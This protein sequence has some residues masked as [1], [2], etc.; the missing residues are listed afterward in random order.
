MVGRNMI[1]I[2]TAISSIATQTS[3]SDPPAKLLGRGPQEKVVVAVSMAATAVATGSQDDGSSAVW[4]KMTH[5]REW[6]AL[7]NPPV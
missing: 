5:L 4:R 7:M 3:N 6:A 2:N 1:D